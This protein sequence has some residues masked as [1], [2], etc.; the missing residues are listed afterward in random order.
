M[1][2]LNGRC[3]NVRGLLLYGFAYREMDTSKLL[4]VPMDTSKL[5]D[6]P[7]VQLSYSSIVCS[8]ITEDR[9]PEE[10]LPIMLSYDP[11][12]LRDLQDADPDKEPIFKWLQ[13]DGVPGDA[14]FM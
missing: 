12:E 4:D 1:F 3:S 11:Q 2:S 6:V 7:S 13:E 8:I 5:L 14:E 9:P 10:T